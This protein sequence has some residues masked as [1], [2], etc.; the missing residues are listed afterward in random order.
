[1]SRKKLARWDVADRKA[2]QSPPKSLPKGS[3]TRYL[4]ARDVRNVDHAH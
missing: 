4:P 3:R 1:M 2:N